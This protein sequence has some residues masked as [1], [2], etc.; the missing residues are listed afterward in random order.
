MAK[1]SGSSPARLSS[2]LRILAM[3]D[4][5]V[6][7]E[8]QQAAPSRETPRERQWIY[9]TSLDLWDRV[10][11]GGSTCPLLSLS[12]PRQYIRPSYVPFGLSSR[13]V[14]ARSGLVPQDLSSGGLSSSTRLFL[15]T[16]ARKRAMQSQTQS[17]RALSAEDGFSKLLSVNLVNRG[18]TVRVVEHANVVG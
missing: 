18:L 7:E 10:V 14:R 6:A 16:A 9:L 13:E 1:G 12:C 3:T 8:H 17:Q 5:R 11:V 15:P 2:A 4:M